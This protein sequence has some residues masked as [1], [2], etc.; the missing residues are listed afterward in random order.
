MNRLDDALADLNAALE[1][2]PSRAASLYMRGG[3]RK[4]QGDAT[5][6]AADLAA[7]RLISPQ[8]DEDYARFG[9]KP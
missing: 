1:V 7:A 4:Q 5:R 9:I 3:I 6:A 2:N 8:I